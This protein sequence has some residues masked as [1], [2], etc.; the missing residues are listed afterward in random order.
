MAAAGKQGP[1]LLFGVGGS[2]ALAQAAQLLFLTSLFAAAL[3]VHNCVWLS[4]R[5]TD[6]FSTPGRMA[7]ELAKLRRT[8]GDYP[9]PSAICPYR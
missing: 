5:F 8:S 3:A 7:S 6:R 1:G 2:G 9:G 4:R